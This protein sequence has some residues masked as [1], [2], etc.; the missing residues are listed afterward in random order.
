MCK[1]GTIARIPFTHIN[2]H[3]RSITDIELHR[4][5]WVECHRLEWRKLNAGLMPTAHRHIS[6]NAVQFVCGCR[7]HI[8]I[9][10]RL[11]SC[12]QIPFFFSFSS[13]S[14]PKP[15]LFYPAKWP[16]CLFHV[17]VCM[18]SVPFYHLVF[19]F[20]VIAVIVDEAGEQAT[21]RTD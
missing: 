13:S 5:L 8:V 7:W 10:H 14:S 3:T 1:W 18:C 6:S 16:L 19:W 17:C 12:C 4:R 2:T 15:L 9:I 20:V 21:H 11:I